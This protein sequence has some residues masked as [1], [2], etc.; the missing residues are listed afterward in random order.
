[1]LKSFHLLAANCK[2]QDCVLDHLEAANL[3]SAPSDL[4]LA[5]LLRQGRVDWGRGLSGFGS[6]T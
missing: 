6:R 5:Y 3:L 2:C 1:M 4:Q